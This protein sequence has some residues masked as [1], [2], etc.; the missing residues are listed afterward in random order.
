MQHQLF[1]SPSLKSLLPT[2]HLLVVGDVVFLGPVL[3][4]TLI[5]VAQISTAHH[6]TVNTGS[7]CASVLRIPI[8]PITDLTT[9]PRVAK[10]RL[11]EYSSS[12]QTMQHGKIISWKTD[13]GFGFI[14]YAP[15]A[16]KAY[17]HISEVSPDG[18]V[19]RPGDEVEYVPAYDEKGRP[20]ARKAKILGVEN[21]TE[22]DQVNLILMGF[23]I[24]FLAAIGGVF[25]DFFA[26]QIYIYVS[27]LT[28]LAYAMDKR[29]AWL[30]QW[31]IAEGLLHVL[32]LAG[33]WPG[34]LFALHFKNH[35]ISKLKYKIELWGIMFVHVCLWAYLYTIQTTVQELLL[36]IGSRQQ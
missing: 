28:Y 29:R 1:V 4:G 36:G 3:K 12:V 23:A 11:T 24:V 10:Y 32:E 5:Q 2:T 6:H 7:G 20:M 34:A 30:S 31:R 9:A 35:K 27:I 17:L 33:G 18:Y 8:A 25:R 14:K 26:F 19:P 15:N 21:N 22:R 16:K 13:R